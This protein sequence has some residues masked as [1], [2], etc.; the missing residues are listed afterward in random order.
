MRPAEARNASLIGCVIKCT[1]GRHREHDAC[2]HG[3]RARTA[4]PDCR[5][6]PRGSVGSARRSSPE[7][8]AARPMR[9]QP[10][11][12]TDADRMIL[13]PGTAGSGVIS[14]AYR[15]FE[16]LSRA[17]CFRPGKQQV[18]NVDAGDQQKEA[19]RAEQHHHRFLD[20]ADHLVVELN[21][22]A[23]CVSGCIAW[24]FCDCFWPNS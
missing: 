21:I 12:R 13:P 20:V 18:G 1:T 5:G 16:Q 8:F 6:R 4:A 24:K 7:S 9:A 3:T 14:R 17:A 2:D 19:D 10:Q 23:G 15:L 11:E 22:S